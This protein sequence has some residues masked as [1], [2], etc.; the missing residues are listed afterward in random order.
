MYLALVY[1]SNKPCTLLLW[2][3]LITTEFSLK[4]NKDKVITGYT[5]AFLTNV[6]FLMWRS[7]EKNCLNN[8]TP[9]CSKGIKLS[10]KVYCITDETIWFSMC[11]Q[12]ERRT[13]LTNRFIYVYIYTNIVKMWLLVKNIWTNIWYDTSQKTIHI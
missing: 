11:R 12:I 4:L 8:R 1:K 5:N 13:L 7:F 10:G 6:F 3:N 2:Y 9:K